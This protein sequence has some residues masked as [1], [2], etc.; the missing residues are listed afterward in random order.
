[1]IIERGIRLQSKTFYCQAI[2][3][4]LDGTIVDTSADLWLSLQNS[5]ASHGFA[6]ISKALFFDTLHFGIDESTRLILKEQGVEEDVI[7]QAAEDY[8]NGYRLLNHGL[9]VMYEGVLTLL[10]CLKESG[11]KLAI[12]TNKESDLTAEILRVLQ[13]EDF[14]EVVIGID[15]ALEPKPSPKPLQQALSYLSVSAE[16][17]VFIGDSNIDA[18]ASSA[19]GIPFLLHSSGF[20]AA[21]VQF[22]NV[23]GCFDS[24]AEIQVFGRQ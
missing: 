6:K 7:L 8:K 22:A 2:L 12:C 20:G 18:M 16:D 1:M 15:Q 19:A 4:D 13:I 14:F 11:I 5:F 23:D 17:C 3:L 21:Q 9:T 10:R 24:F